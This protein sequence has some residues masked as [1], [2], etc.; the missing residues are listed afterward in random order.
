MNNQM[1][2]SCALLL[3]MVEAC[4]AQTGD[5]AP[6][7]LK[8]MPA[9][10]PIPAPQDVT[11][12]GE[13]IPAPVETAPAGAVGFSAGAGLS[14]WITYGQPNCCGPVGGDGPIWTELYV[15]TGFGFVIGGGEISDRLDTGWMFQVGGRSI[16]FN[17]AMD[18]A[19]TVD[20]SISNI[21]NNG[22]GNQ[23]PLLI[24]GIPSTV[25]DLNRTM[26]N[27]TVGQQYWLVGNGDSCD[28]NW[29]VGW[30]AGLLY[31]A[32]RLGLN[33]TGAFTFRRITSWNWGPTAAIHSDVEWPWGDYSIITGVRL[34]WHNSYNNRLPV[35]DT[36]ITDLN[37][38]FTLGL[39]Y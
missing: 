6:M 17:S 21:C 27:A 5:A 38:L 37:L 2:F 3:A 29:R 28:R 24:D 10:E 36:E 19:C 12:A 15:R 31:G 8:A 13:P 34:E 30:D 39:R 26:V 35:S 22:E 20:L 25:R 18:R 1:V 7:P 32:S 16:F 9:A 4:A 23:A 33:Q 11:P 14:H